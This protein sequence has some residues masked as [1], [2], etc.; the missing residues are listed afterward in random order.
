MAKPWID[1]DR[2]D[3]EP[4]TFE[5][6]IGGPTRRQVLRFPRDN[7]LDYPGTIQFDLL[8]ALELNTSNIKGFWST[9]KGMTSAFGNTFV[10][11]YSSDGAID[12]NLSPEDRQKL[13][14]EHGL[15]RARLAATQ[16]TSNFVT[17][18]EVNRVN[19]IDRQ[20]LSVG[21]CTLYLPQQI[22]IQ[23]GVSYGD[24][25]LGR[26]GQAAFQA[27][28]QTGDITEAGNVAAAQAGRNTVEF[29][30]GF[31]PSNLSKMSSSRAAFIVDQVQRKTLGRGGK[32]GGFRQSTS[33]AISAG[34]GVSVNPNKLSLFRSVNLRRFQLNFKLIPNSRLEAQE[35]EKIIKFFR[36]ELYP[37]GIYIGGVSVGYKHPKKFR[38]TMAYRDKEVATRLLPVYLERFDTNY[39]P[40]TMSMHYDG[41]RPYFPEIDISMAFVEERALVK[42][43]ITDDLNNGGGH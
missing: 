39:N 30:K 27:L 10:E 14:D 8:Q 38:I 13:E 23:D 26:I 4:K 28:Q 17:E 6:E 7:Q 18:R 20:T 32:A 3:T 25:D 29:L 15:D 40:S 36:S 33:G 22:V 37:E 24:I 35:I 16:N 11:A 1:P 12:D 41:E 34:L 21:K 42:Q 2:P 19:R 43:D 9:A 31:S 5:T